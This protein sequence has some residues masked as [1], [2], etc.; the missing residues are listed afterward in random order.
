[1][2][3]GILSPKYFFARDEYIPNTHIIAPREKCAMTT[4]K[5]LI[6]AALGLGMAVPVVYF[7]MQAVAAPF[8]PG[9]SFLSR[10]ASTLGSAES[11]APAVFNVGCLLLGIMALLASWGFFQAFRL[12]GAS[13]WFGG[14]VALAVAL[15]GIGSINAGLF[16]LPDERHMSGVGAV[17]GT[18]SFTLVFLLPI[19]MWKLPEA[20]AIKRYFI[21]NIVVVVGLLPIVSGLIQRFLMMAH[22]EWPS[23]QNFLNNDQGLLQRIAAATVVFPIGVSAWFLRRRVKGMGRDEQVRK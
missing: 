23:Y 16:P 2:V 7:G 21:L 6:L 20:R 9:Y 4:N 14:L 11:N 1:L 10:D 22:T 3:R 17:L 13:R 8:C 18:I 15:F 12:L 19:A 5:K